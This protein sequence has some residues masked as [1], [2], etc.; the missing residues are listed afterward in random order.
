[1]SVLHS[2]LSGRRKL[3][4]PTRIARIA[5]K[6]LERA[7]ESGRIRCPKPLRLSKR[8][9]QKRE[10]VAYDLETTRIAVGNPRPL[11][12]TGVGRDFYF[13]GRIHN[14]EHL[15]DIL[16][17]RFLDPERH[18]TRYIAWNGNRFDV[19]FIGAALL[20]SNDYILRPYL[21]R[22]KSLRGL[23]V[24]HKET[25]REWEFLD[26]LAMTLGNKPCTLKEF[27]KTFAPEH[28]KLDA[29]DWEKEEFDADNP[30]HVAYA[31]RDSEG[32]YHGM[33]QAES[34]VRDHF[35]QV[36]QPTIGN[37]GI[38]LFQQHMPENV[39]C[40]APPYAVEKIIRN[41]VMRGG[42]CSASR[43]YVGPVWKYD[44]NQA[45][46]AAMR[47]ATLP[48][49]RCIRTDEY[50]ADKCGIWLVTA[51][52]PEN[53]VPFY[54]RSDKGVGVSVLGEIPGAWLTSIEVEQLERERWDI[55]I[56]DGYYWDSSFTMRPYVDAL[57]QLRIN[58]PGGP[59][60]AQGEM[61]KAI[62]NNSYGKTVEEL[63]GYE[64]VMAAERPEGYFQY[65]NESDEL[66][67]IW[68][69]FGEQQSRDYH[70]PQLGAFITA[71]VRMVVRRAI[72]VD[73]DAWLYS[74]TDCCMFTRPVALDID[75]GRYGAW[76]IEAEGEHYRIIAK[77]VYCALDGSE[78]KAKGMT[79]S[80]PAPVWNDAANK[81]EVRRLNMDDFAR[82]YDGKSP[83]I[84][85]TQRLNFVGVMSG[86][87]MFVERVKVGQRMKGET[88][89][90]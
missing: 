6:K 84:K 26:G 10:M 76:K 47:E 74:D 25:K 37:L 54:I 39:E 67:H 78:M 8:R 86:G 28:H 62:G 89:V 1:V 46:C 14:L 3:S 32:L 90:A 85:Q 77:K 61:M 7:K 11:Y 64:V 27:L 51:R 41:H 60:S 13:A 15:R 44:I 38:R 22:T 68:F 70:Q 81:W 4:R 79:I 2:A 36:L 66:Q 55:V 48:A 49:G 12:L 34:I 35:G 87:D 52:H 9:G 63:G 53:R 73:A 75:P 72:L 82:W 83:R 69:K 80:K 59:K 56:A 57:E 42:F 29:P 88:H 71:H 45:Y 30:A 33:Q 24:T 23:K 16:I 19:F 18:R 40:W 20:H 43:Q 21:T 5:D 31:V 17:S 58:G 50:T 65:Q